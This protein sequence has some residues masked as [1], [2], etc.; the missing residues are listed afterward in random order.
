MIDQISNYSISQMD[1]KNNLQNDN[2][3][4][5]NTDKNPYYDCINPICNFQ[6]D[7]PKGLIKKK[8]AP[9]T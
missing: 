1:I 9:T 7:I 5:T 8:K 4:V 6:T 2:V 3:V